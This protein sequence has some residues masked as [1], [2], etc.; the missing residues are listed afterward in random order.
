ML[1]FTASANN[2]VASHATLVLATGAPADDCAMSSPVHPY[3]S[4]S[5]ILT[6]MLLNAVIAGA[7]GLLL[8]RGN[9]LPVLESVHADGGPEHNERIM[10][11]LASRIPCWNS[12]PCVDM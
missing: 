7:V 1:A 6:L 8:C 3:G 5:S 12:M 11:P 2:P 9:E 4:I 10:A